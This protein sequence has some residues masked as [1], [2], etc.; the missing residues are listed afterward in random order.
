MP[1]R[2]EASR[3]ADAAGAPPST[4]G[5]ADIVATLFPILR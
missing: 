2:R 5:A 4:I 3:K 1:C